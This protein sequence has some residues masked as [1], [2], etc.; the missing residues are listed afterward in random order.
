[1]G[2]QKDDTRTIRGMVAVKE[3]DSWREYLVNGVSF[4]DILLLSR[5]RILTCGTYA[6]EQGEFTKKRY[7]ALTY[8]SDGGT[9]WSLVYVNPK[10]G[11]INAL[12][13][14]DSEHVWAVGDDG[15]IL[16]LDMARQQPT[17]TSSK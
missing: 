4:S 17:N 5:S 3:D 11:K 6:P 2:G 12:G 10:A 7:V 15:L 13:A 8:S 16:R 14:V 9:S 1:V